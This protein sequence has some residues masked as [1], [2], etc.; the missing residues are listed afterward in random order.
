MDKKINN[1]Y[2]NKKVVVF[3]AT[4]FK[5]SW[6]CLWL[7]IMGA[8]VY[9]IGHNPN[10][11]KKLFNQL[12]LSKKIQLQNIDIRNSNKIK[13]YIKKI[14][15]SIIFHLAAQPIISKS[16]EEPKYTYEVN[17]QGTLNI[18]DSLKNLK[19]IRSVV[20]VTSDK[21]YQSNNS[22]I[23]FK[24]NDKL[25]G[26]DP[27]SGSKA[28]A[29][30]IVN[31]YYESFFKNKTKTGIATARAGNVIGG[32][33]WSKDRLIPDAINFL[34]NDKEIVIR[35]PNFNRPWQ[36]VLEPLYGYLI[37]AQK[38]YSNSDKFSGPWNFGTERNTV[39]SVEQIIHKIIKEWG[40][41]KYKTFNK[42]KFYEQVNLQ[43]DIS[44]AKK[45]LKWKPKFSIDECVKITIEWY[46]EVLINKTG[47]QKIT[48]SQILNYMNKN[49]KK[50]N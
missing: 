17:S 14:R 41:G 46:K 38:L 42:K 45:I 25:G 50:K 48:R 49:E 37:L 1:F 10:N 44:K 4:G 22:T 40:K 39:T 21:C 19:F 8:N 6:L 33:D 7:K 23:G 11:N 26:V 3:G 47:V 15:P 20:F 31:T 32:G 43:L 16:Y 24:E 18:I 5:G 28:C 2:K 35:N 36:H 9:G 30:I 27:Y 29:E 34:N 13:K 12:N